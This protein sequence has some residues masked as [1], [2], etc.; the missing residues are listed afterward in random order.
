[1]AGFTARYPD[2]LLDVTLD[3]EVVDI[4]TGG[5]DAALRIGEVI[6]RDTMAVA[7]GMNFARSQAN[8]WTS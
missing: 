1:M 7:L 5:F 6:E 2:V 3:D 4:V 8:P